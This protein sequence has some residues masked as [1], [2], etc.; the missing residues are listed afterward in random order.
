MEPEAG[1]FSGLEVNGIEVVPGLDEA[2]IC[3]QPGFTDGDLHDDFFEAIYAHMTTGDDVLTSAADPYLSSPL[4]LS[5]GFS[6]SYGSDPELLP[7]YGSSFDSGSGA[8]HPWRNERVTVSSYNSLDSRCLGLMSSFGDPI[9]S[10]APPSVDSFTEYE[11]PRGID[12]PRAAGYHNPSRVALSGVPEVPHMS[13]FSPEALQEDIRGMDLSEQSLMWDARG[14]YPGSFNS[15][16]SD[17]FPSLFAPGPSYAA[18]PNPSVIRQDGTNMV[19]S[20]SQQSATSDQLPPQGET[21]LAYAQSIGSND[22]RADNPRSIA[23]VPLRRSRSTSQSSTRR[24][25]GTSRTP[26]SRRVTLEGQSYPGPV[27]GSQDSGL[28]VI[29]YR[30]NGTTQALEKIGEEF[31][32]GR[33]RGGRKGPLPEDAKRTTALVR[34]K[35]ACQS[36]KDRKCKVSRKP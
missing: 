25:R 21:A 31:H 9:G 20:G 17:S 5:F 6:Q 15:F 22:A 34:G 16:S 10:T 28:E 24:T 11:D 23:S 7:S 13:Q 8:V 12:I 36:C 30:A 2:Q 14:Y 4:E 1:D 27:T 26:R 33:K 35:G 3:G 32:L 18:W 29:Q 19:I